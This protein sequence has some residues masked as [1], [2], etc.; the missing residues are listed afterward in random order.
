MGGQSEELDT[1]HVTSG[2]T[3]PVA[4]EDI[5]PAALLRMRRMATLLLVGVTCLFAA[6]LALQPLW[7]WLAPVRAFAEAAMVGGIAD[8]FAVVALF[9]R[10]MGLPIPHTAVIPRNHARIAGAIGRFVA[11]NFLASEATARRLEELDPAGRLGMWLIQAG[12]LDR[13]GERI[14]GVFPPLLDIVGEDRVRTLAASTGRQALDLV[15]NAPRMADMLAFMA[16]RGYHHIL[17]DRTLAHY[18]PESKDARRY[19][20]RLQKSRTSLACSTGRSPPETDRR[21]CDFS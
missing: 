15:V 21:P 18:G 7:P 5:R 10:P 6:S 13:V 11:G 3:P 19:L 12:N 20:A 16:S 14:T 9:R 8:W 17:L 2:I 1:S 4:T